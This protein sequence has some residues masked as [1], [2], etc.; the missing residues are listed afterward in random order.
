VRQIGPL[1]SRL[2]CLSGCNFG[3]RK[4]LQKGSR[5]E[6]SSEVT[7]VRPF[8]IRHANLV[9]GQWKG[10]EYFSLRT[11]AFNIDGEDKGQSSAAGRQKHRGG[12]TGM[13]YTA[14]T[15]VVYIVYMVKVSTAERIAAAA[16]RLLDK[17]GAD[18]VTMRRVAKAVSI[19]PMAV[20]RH[21]ADHE[22]LLNAL[23]DT[24]FASL[25][26]RL[27]ATALPAD[28]E[29][30]L[31][32]NLDVFIDFALEKPQLFELMFLRRR[33]GA[34]KFPED[35]R[36]GR[37]PTAKFSA[38]ALEAGMKD[39]IFRKDDVWEISFES[40]ALLQGLVMLYLGGRF[41]GTPD[42]FRALCHRAFR[43]YFHGIRK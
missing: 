39:G 42:E 7:A 8:F 9:R 32:E 13:E 12:E 28:P 31:V 33:K 11:S 5:R 40:G 1:V 24:G 36:E 17:E 43:R 34:R 27:E 38:T 30:R 18:A 29:R 41:G 35:F 15:L 20:Y 25:A 19:T 2:W 22:A 4:A 23:A 10:G 14:Y 37:S 16:G 21:Y 3:S 26:A 6:P